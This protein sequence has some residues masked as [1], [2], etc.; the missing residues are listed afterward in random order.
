MTTEVVDEEWQEGVDEFFAEFSL[1]ASG[2]KSTRRKN[3]E[4]H[5]TSVAQ[6]Q[7][8]AENREF[9]RAE[10]A[11]EARRR[12]TATVIS[13]ATAK[14]LKAATRK[15]KKNQR[16][17]H[18]K[19]NGGAASVKSGLSSASF[20]EKRHSSLSAASL[21]PSLEEHDSTTQQAEAEP[22]SSCFSKK[23]R[24]I[25]AKFSRKL[26]RREAEEEHR[27]KYRRVLR[28]QRR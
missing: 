2:E 19:P 17:T 12:I 9:D 27:V 28:K 18:T 11:E 14:E 10:S 13:R 4:A 1:S 21:P 26:A 22:S 24:K 8:K 16:M 23:R 6:S 25:D 15:A 3:A 5:Q 7:K 20:S